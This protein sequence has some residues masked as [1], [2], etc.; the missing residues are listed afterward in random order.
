MNKPMGAYADQMHQQWRR[1]P[2]SVDQT[3]ADHF[4]GQ[5]QS[6]GA[7]L[8]AIVRAIQQAGIGQQ[9]GGDLSQAQS[10]G[11]KVGTLI[12]AFMTHGH[13]QADLDPL[14]LD[15]TLYQ[16]TNTQGPN[17]ILRNILSYEN[18]GFTEQDLDRTFH[19]HVP[20]NF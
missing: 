12:R 7:D 4:S 1:D 18:Y 14:E 20:D 8:S 10:E 3:W 11:F 16:N 15:K 13:L 2:L 17:E 5:G 6:A 19:V 9:S